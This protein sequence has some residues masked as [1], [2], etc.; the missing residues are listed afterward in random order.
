MMDN[1]RKENPRE[2]QWMK[3]K[4]GE[5]IMIKKANMVEEDQ[6]KN[7]WNNNNKK[8]NKDKKCKNN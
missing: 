2:K 4:R 3:M 7:N 1:R 8:K 5:K 6:M